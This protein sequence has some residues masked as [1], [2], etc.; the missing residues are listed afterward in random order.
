M[1]D[2]CNH[3]LDPRIVFGDRPLPIA[4][5]WYSGRLEIDQGEALTYF[6]MGWGYRHETRLRVC[7]KQGKLVA[8]RRYDQTRLLRRHFDRFVAA[9][10]DWHQIL[11][12]EARA[13]LQPLGGLT[14]AG[15]KALGRPELETEGILHTWPASLTSDESAEIAGYLLPHCIRAPEGFTLAGRSWPPESI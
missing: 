5:D 12:D 2:C 7:L 15:L 9:N 10:P 11:I 3:P 6:H 4:A 1:L 8:R 13:E 14:V